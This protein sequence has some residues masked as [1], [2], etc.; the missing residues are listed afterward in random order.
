[1]FDYLLSH[2]QQRSLDENNLK[3]PASILL[4]IQTMQDSSTIQKNSYKIYDIL[5]KIIRNRIK[6]HKTFLYT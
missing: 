6:K 2:L 1:M 3:M 5:I 4:T